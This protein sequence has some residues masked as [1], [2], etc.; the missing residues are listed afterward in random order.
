MLVIDL[1][2]HYKLWV[3]NACN[4]DQKSFLK[5]QH[6]ILKI[7]SDIVFAVFW[8]QRNISLN[9]FST[10]T[11]W[12]ISLSTT[13]SIRLRLINLFIYSIERHNYQKVLLV[14]QILRP[15]GNLTWE[16]LMNNLMSPPEVFLHLHIFSK[17]RYEGL[18]F[19]I[20]S[21][22]FYHCN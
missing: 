1:L 13:Y 8:E 11:Q 3:L 19:S 10:S 4:R 6:E 22:P 16:N 18:T 21:I 7:V 17:R 12:G 9:F 5:F 14:W 20:P 15:V 2:K